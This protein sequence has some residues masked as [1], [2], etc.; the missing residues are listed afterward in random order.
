VA[1][2][3]VV[4]G[5]QCGGDRAFAGCGAAG[6]GAGE[7]AAALSGGL[8]DGSVAPGRVS[9]LPPDAEAN[10]MLTAVQEAAGRDGRFLVVC[11]LGRLVADPR[12]RRLALV[13]AGSTRENAYRRGL[14]WDWVVSAMVHGSHPETL[15]LA[16]VLVDREAAAALSRPGGPRELLDH[17]RVPLWGHVSPYAPGRFGRDGSPAPGG[18]GSFARAVVE[19]LAEGVPGLPAA[20]SPADLHPAVSER[21]DAQA[22]GRELLWERLPVPAPGGRLLLR[23]PAAL[24]GKLAGMPVSRELLVALQPE[25]ASS[26]PR[27]A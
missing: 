2:D 3:L 27:S 11:L 13:T 15:L 22:G 12:Q 24:R 9:V 21:T 19:V 25:R 23:N 7:L 26:D 10:T 1:A 6:A 4:I 20:V 8:F 18:S 5:A 14:A 16:D 17:S